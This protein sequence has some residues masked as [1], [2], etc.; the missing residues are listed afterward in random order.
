MIGSL[1]LFARS[2]PTRLLERRPCSEQALR[3]VAA[4]LVK[5]GWMTEW[6]GDLAASIEAGLSARVPK[7]RYFVPTFV[8]EIGEEGINGSLQ[9]DEF[10][11]DGIGSIGIGRVHDMELEALDLGPKAMAFPHDLLHTVFSALECSPG[12]D[13]FGPLR[14]V[15][16]IRDGMWHGEEDERNAIEEGMIDE[17]C[18]I[19]R[20]A[21]DAAFAPTLQKNV[22][23]SRP[24]LQ[25]LA[26]GSDAA[27]QVA[28]A[29]LPFCESHKDLLYAQLE[30]MEV[31]RVVLSVP[32]FDEIGRVFDD[33]AEY[34]AQGGE[35]CDLGWGRWFTRTSLRK[36]LRSADT[37]LKL[38]KH[39]DD[40]LR[41]LAEIG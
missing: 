10:P 18:A 13:V 25:R 1:P 26:E 16:G 35:P 36:T 33:M 7:F 41:V 28:K 37:I 8:C 20:V 38:T 5:L 6:T 4:E 27:A 15:D 40:L 22:S 31:P 12:L 3:F 32:G 34:A 30:N 9:S 2:V 21:L 11:E 39:K 14:T 24:A 23:L 17:D 19:T 29:L